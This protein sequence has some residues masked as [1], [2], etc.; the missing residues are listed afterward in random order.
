M[1]GNTSGVNLNIAGVGEIRALTIGLDS[2]CTVATHGVG[3]KEVSVTITTGSDYNG[4][5]REALQLTCNEILGDDT[6]CVAVNDH[7][8]FHLVTCEQ[9]HFTGMHLRAQGRRS[10]ERRVG[11][12]CRSRWSPYH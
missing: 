11:K 7:E 4:I 3:R 9:L 12:E 2:G 6:A 8:I 1:Y 10:E 5:G